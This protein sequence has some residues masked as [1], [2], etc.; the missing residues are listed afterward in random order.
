MTV[1]D[2]GKGLV[3]YVGTES[4]SPLFY[5][6]LIALAATKS[7]VALNRNIPAGV[8]VSIRQKEERKIFFVMNYTDAT[9]TVPMEQAYRNALTGKMETMELQIPAYEVKVLTEP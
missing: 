7:G 8:E 4:K 3:Y 6:R 2:D 5:D 1:N 9:Q